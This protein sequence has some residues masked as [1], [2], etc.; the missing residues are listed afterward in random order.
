MTL[1]E[2]KKAHVT[3]EGPQSL[4][5][6]RHIAVEQR[7]TE[8]IEKEKRSRERLTF[9]QVFVE[10][11][12]LQAKAN[13]SAGSYNREQ[14]LFKHWI[15]PVIGNLPLKDITPSSM[16]CIKKNMVEAGLAPRSIRYALAVVRQVF[17][18]TRHNNLFNGES[19]TCKVK[20]PQ[21]DNRR[22]R[23]LT[24]DE[25][26]QLLEALRIR[27]PQ[28]Y[29]MALI[30]LYCGL[31]AGEIFSLT[32]G[33][34][35]ME[36]GIM[37]LR[38]TKSGRNRAAFMTKAVKDMLSRK[39]QG[40]NNDLVFLGRGGVMITSMS[41]VFDRV[42]QELGL[43]DG[44]TDPRQKAVFH[45][46][47]HTYASWLVERGVNLYAVKELL[48]HSTLA[49]TERYSHLGNG[50]LQNAVKVLEHNGDKKR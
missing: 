22:L 27:I 31:R 15:S 45:T 33:D 7:E 10:T 36:R 4:A 1:A 30:S 9:G 38:D 32:W 19:P 28:V 23:F 8:Q 16:E 24:P 20:M 48:G 42:V 41:N 11:Y 50:T 3:G 6:K 34:I 37:M 29:E 17:N 14:S 40:E 47:R 49:M 35:D 2:L 46:L 44:V 12:F 13:K 18:F 39:E 26:D 43:N 5:E 21:A 25:A